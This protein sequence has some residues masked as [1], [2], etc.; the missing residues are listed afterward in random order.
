MRL[1]YLF[2]F[3]WDSSDVL[4][5]HLHWTF[6]VSDRRVLSTAVFRK[7]FERKQLLDYLHAARYEY[8]TMTRA[9]AIPSYIV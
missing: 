3:F 4:Y 2:I 5:Q 9:E 6:R 1:F 7:L 8:A